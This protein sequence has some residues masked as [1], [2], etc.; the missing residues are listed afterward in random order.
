MELEKTNLSTLFSL[1]PRLLEYLNRKKFFK[2]NDIESKTLEKEYQITSRDKEIINAYLSNNKNLQKDLTND[3]YCEFIKT[4]SQRPITSQELMKTDPR[5]QRLKKKLIKEKQAL[6]SKE[7]ISNIS[8]SYDLFA[9]TSYASMGGDFAIENREDN[10]INQVYYSSL[11][12]PTINNN[13]RDLAHNNK[14]FV[15]ENKDPL[16]K[17]HK[18]SNIQYNQVAYTNQY[19][20]Y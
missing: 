14:Y 16:L 3:L 8:R 18:N 13:S 5:F 20:S 17:R 19:N 6:N 1:E 10:D 15:D 12:N 7:D 11:D 9:N 4:P 2:K